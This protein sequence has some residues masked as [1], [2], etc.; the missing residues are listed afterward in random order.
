VLPVKIPRDF[1]TAALWA[2]L[3][4][5]GSWVSA[6]AG[7]AIGQAYIAPGPGYTRSAGTD[8]DLF[9]FDSVYYKSIAESGYSYNGDPSSS[10]NIVFAPMYPVL[11]RVLSF[12]PGLDVLSAGFLVNK[13]LLILALA[14]FYLL[15][16]EWYAPTRVLLVLMAIATG[17]SC[18]ALNGY[19]SE[20]TMLFFLALA[21]WAF[22]QRRFTLCAAASAGLGAS[23]LA[24]LPMALVF[25]VLL[26]VEARRSQGRKRMKFAAC[27]AA[28]LSGAAAYLIYIGF[29]F[30][31]PF[32]LLDTVQKTSWAMYHQDID[33]GLFLTGGY[34]FDYWL[35][36]AAKHSATF[37][38]IQTIN[39]VW[40]TLG[41]GACVY[42][43]AVWKRHLLTYVFVPYIL[44]IYYSNA[45]SPFLIST[46]RFVAAVPPVFL[47]AS[48]LPAW[49]SQ[50]AAIW[51]TAAVS[52]VLLLLNLGYGC[53]HTAAF[54]QGV[55]FW[56]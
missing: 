12:L 31:N 52:L 8:P 42:L 15:L 34:L 32:T 29:A 11:A 6:R 16:I 17:A 10:P 49:L 43:A 50:R 23:R 30:G 51:I 5:C 46:H 56:F 4:V 21:T 14:F 54:T 9:R 18:Y 47:M 33:W 27:A 19:Y 36:A 1:R 38:D 48:A 2:V 26:A 37:T 7:V 44:F 25:A 45:S 35:S 28:C 22:Q 3:I 55:W 41:L 24:A 53:L 13:I 40:M 39:L 20:S